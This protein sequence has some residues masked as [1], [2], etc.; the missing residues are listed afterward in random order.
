MEN[1]RRKF[2]TRRVTFPLTFA[3]SPQN[4]A[5]LN[6]THFYDLGWGNSSGYFNLNMHSHEGTA[7]DDDVDVEYFKEAVG[8]R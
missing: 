1:D 7:D 3:Y 4:K 8:D 6:G 2:I 5:A